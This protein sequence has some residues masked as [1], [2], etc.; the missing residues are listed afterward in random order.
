MIVRQILY[1]G[2]A[3]TLACDA[4]CDKAFGWSKRPKT[5]PGAHEDDYALLADHEVGT[6]PAD[7]GTYEGECAKPRTQEERL[8]KWCARECERSITVN[9]ED[10]V[11]ELRDLSR[12]FYNC[13]PHVREEPT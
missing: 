4:K 1:F 9:R 3:T 7:P 10:G 12:R 6:A 2:Q 13:A 5:P 8:N 11:E